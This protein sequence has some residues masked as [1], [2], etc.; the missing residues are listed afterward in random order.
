MV[1]KTET[2]AFSGMKIWPGHGRR[3]VRQDS[4]TFLFM[5]HK[6]SVFFGMKRNPRK[7]PWTQYYRR[8]HKKGTSAEEVHKRKVRKVASTAMSRGIVGASIEEI[9]AKRTENPQRRAAARDA[10]VRDVKERKRTTAAAK[11]ADR[12]KTSAQVAKPK[13]AQKPAAQRPTKAGGKR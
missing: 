8:L 3:F 11:K 5:H 9:K 1:I 6:C 7:L 13:V 10:A 2:C 4:R 12:P